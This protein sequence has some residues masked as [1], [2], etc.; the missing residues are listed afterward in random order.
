[1]FLHGKVASSEVNGPGKRAVLWLQGCTLACTG[2]HNPETHKF[3]GK[4]YV[5]NQDIKS[6]LLELPDIEGVT[7]SGGEPMQHVSD[8][9]DILQFLRDIR[10]ELSVGMY[11]GYTERELEFGHWRTFYAGQMLQ[12]DGETWKHVKERIDY[13]VMGRFNVQKLTTEKPLCGSANQNIVT[14]TDRYT[15]KDF[16][17]VQA[18]EV[19]ISADGLVS[20]TGYPGVEFLRAVETNLK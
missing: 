4:S 7:F 15:A 16:K 17:Q 2:C 13:A 20:I 11:T 18:A 8:L 6:W 3:T 14:F 19:T 5:D 10:P 12:G 9:I 1:M